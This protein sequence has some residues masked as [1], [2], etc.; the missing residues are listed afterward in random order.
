MSRTTKQKPEKNREEDK[1]IEE[2]EFQLEMLKIQVKHSDISSQ[3]LAVV[4]IE[5]SALVSLA[6]TYL[7]AGLMGGN[8]GD[9]V[10]AAAILIALGILF[11]YTLRHFG[12]KK[13]G[14]F[15]EKNL[16]NELQPIRDRFITKKEKKKN[17]TV[18]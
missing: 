14:E 17:E 8:L 7:S 4:A 18:S 11:R 13:V 12:S 9:F 2:R 10:I 15:L 6:V 1:M 3:A 16:D 5:F